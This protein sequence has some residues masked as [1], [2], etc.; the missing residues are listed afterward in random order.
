MLG[1]AVG[2]STLSRRCPPAGATLTEPEEMIFS[3]VDMLKLGAEKG[4]NKAGGLR[5]Y[6]HG[7]GWGHGPGLL[8]GW[9]R[10]GA[11]RRRL[12]ATGSQ[13]WKNSALTPAL[14]QQ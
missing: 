10:P 5:G 3:G 11:A 9:M 13:G 1:E 4:E 7:R 8:M 2:G 12:G 6:G 14:Q